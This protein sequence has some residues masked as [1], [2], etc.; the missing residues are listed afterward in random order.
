MQL[1][2]INKHKNESILDETIII[3]LLGKNLDILGLPNN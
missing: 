2:K 1:K 3:E